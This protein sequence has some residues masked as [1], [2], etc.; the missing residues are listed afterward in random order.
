MT[1]NLDLNVSSP[2]HVAQ[3][4]RAAADA[5]RQSCL[6]LQEAWQDD[7][8]GLVWSKLAEV[9]EAAANKADK[10]CDKYFK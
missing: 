10:T 8:A 2:E 1:T 5:Y 7:N 9:L 6:D 3:V 4:L